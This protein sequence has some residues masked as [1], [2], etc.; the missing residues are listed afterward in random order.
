MSK[1]IPRLG[2]IAEIHFWDHSEGMELQKFYLVGRVVRI[3][4]NL[5]AL[6]SWGYSGEDGGSDYNTTEYAIGRRLVVKMRVLR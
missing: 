4:K 6:R 2:D 3:N 1:R 5:I